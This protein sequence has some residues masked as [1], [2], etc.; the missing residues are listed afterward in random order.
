MKKIIILIPLFILAFTSKYTPHLNNFL[1]PIHCEYT[2]HKAAFD[3]C[4]SFKY[5]YPLIVA[6]TLK[7]NL[8]KKKTS[9]K[10]LQFRPDYN[11]QVKCRSYTKDYSKT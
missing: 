9:L 3:I 8:V 10:G 5:K 6:Y 7:G 2:L 4:Y 1:Q 11:L